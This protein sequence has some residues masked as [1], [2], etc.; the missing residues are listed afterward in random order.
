MVARRLLNRQAEAQAVA[1]EREDVLP[2][3]FTVSAAFSES[4]PVFRK[5]E[6]TNRKRVTV[7][8][9]GCHNQ[10]QSDAGK[11]HSCLGGGFP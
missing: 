3:G 2:S 7:R 8:R 5:S 11:S 9:Q 1:S 4:D 6:I 10:T